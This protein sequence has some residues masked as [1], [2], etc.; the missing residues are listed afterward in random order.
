VDHD[1]TLWRARKHLGQTSIGPL[2]GEAAAGGWPV[3][4]TPWHHESRERL[5]LALLDD[6]TSTPSDVR[7]SLAALVVLQRAFG[8]DGWSHETW[9]HIRALAAETVG[10]V[11]SPA[12]Q[13][14]L[15][16]DPPSADRMASLLHA[17][18][19]HAREAN[20]SGSVARNLSRVAAEVFAYLKR[21]VGAPWP[22]FSAVHAGSG[23]PSTRDV[24]RGLVE[25]KA[26]GILNVHGHRKGCA[27]DLRVPPK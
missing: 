5:V 23:I 16:P 3:Y 13:A 22:G 11:L 1:N 18:Q 7:A 17:E 8:E 21:R 12:L 14:A 6:V 15:V 20:P 9:K 25:L 10:E 19:Q 2:S 27:W 4:A 26:K 24:Q